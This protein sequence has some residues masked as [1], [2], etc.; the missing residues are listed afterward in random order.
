MLAMGTGD[1][2]RFRSLYGADGNFFSAISADD[3]WGRRFRG[4]RWGSGT[5]QWNRFGADPA[6]NH[7][8]VRRDGL[9]RQ[10]VFLMAAWAFYFHRSQP[11]WA[12]AFQ[13]DVSSGPQV[14]RRRFAPVTPD[15]PGYRTDHVF[16]RLPKKKLKFNRWLY[17]TGGSRTMFSARA[18]SFFFGHQIEAGSRRG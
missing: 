1:T 18:A 4:I 11:H 10:P 6:G 7:R 17:R 5:F 12:V 8:M 13:T 3:R 9:I 16:Y 15:G 2:A 14:H